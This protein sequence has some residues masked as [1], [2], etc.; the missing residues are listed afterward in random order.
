MRNKNDRKQQIQLKI[1]AHQCSIFLGGAPFFGIIQKAWKTLVIDGLV[2]DLNPS[3][4]HDLMGLKIV[5][6]WDINNWLVV[7]TPVFNGIYSD[8]MGLKIVIQW[9]IV[10]GYT[11]W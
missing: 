2:I 5:I 10:M 3:E 6:Q 7:S 11:L 8:L 4:N 1:V 9:D